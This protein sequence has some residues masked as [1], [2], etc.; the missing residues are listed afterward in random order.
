MGGSL[1]DFIGKNVHEIYG[2]EM[3]EIILEHI[4]TAAL[5]EQSQGYEDSVSLPTGDKWF[6][7]SYT[8]IRN[9]QGEYTG[10]QII[11]QEISQRKQLELEHQKYTGGLEN[12]VKERTEALEAAQAELVR[13]EKLAVMGQM[14]S[15]VGHELRNPLAVIN[16]ALYLL[17]RKVTDADGQISEYLRMIGQDVG[18]ADKIISDLFTFARIKSMDK[19]PTLLLPLVEKIIK[20]FYPPGNIRVNIKLAQDLLPVMVD[21]S[22][23]EQVLINLI[24]NAYQRE[25]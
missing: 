11:S 13:Q 9:P 10:I 19:A 2:L 14:A 17:N 16:N 1:N 6:I 12:L 23:I 24:T 7:S 22:Q 4:N 18:T 8:S 21:V 15:S 25:P 5:A 20:R 3:G